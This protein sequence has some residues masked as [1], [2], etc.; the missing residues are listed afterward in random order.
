MAYFPGDIV[1]INDK[2]ANELILAGV[3][4][5]IEKGSDLPEDMPGRNL[6]INAGLT[7][8]DIKEISDFTQIKGIT[9]TMSANI[10]KYLKKLQQ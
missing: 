6:L 8:N 3:A 9:K 4:I 2:Q 10:V 1:T 7:M 5:L